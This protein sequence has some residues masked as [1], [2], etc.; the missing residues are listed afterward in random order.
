MTHL[1]GAQ[2]MNSPS[3]QTAILALHDIPLALSHTDRVL[4]IEDGRLVLD[5]PAS[6][7]TAA[8][9]SLALWL[10]DNGRPEAAV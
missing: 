8:E 5:A 9:R 7:L 10:V 6:K 3:F 4:V 1:G 2:R